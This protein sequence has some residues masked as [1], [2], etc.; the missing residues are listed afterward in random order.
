MGFGLWSNV[1]TISI[2]IQIELLLGNIIELAWQIGSTNDPFLSSNDKFKVRIDK[3]LPFFWQPNK[4]TKLEKKKKFNPTEPRLGQD[5][6]KQHWVRLGQMWFGLIVYIDLL[7]TE[8]TSQP[9][10]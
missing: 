7:R 4:K 3:F 10:Y 1:F 8:K 6:P 5:R 9:P 2:R